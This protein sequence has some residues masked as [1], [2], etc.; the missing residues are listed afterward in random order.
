MQWVGKTVRWT[1]RN[2]NLLIKPQVFVNVCT[3]RNMSTEEAAKRPI[4]LLGTMAFGGRAN[5]EQS[6]EMVQAFLG[7]GHSRVDTAFMYVDGKSEEVIGGMKLPK[8]VS[9]ATKANPW[10]GKTLKPESVRAQLETSLQRL[11]ADCVDLFYLHAPDHNNPIQDTLRACNDLHKEGKFK[12]L[13]LSNYASWEVAEIVSIC[14]H[15]N[16]IVPTVY[17]GMYN[18]TTRQVETELFPCL[19]YFGMSFYAYNPLAGGLLTGKYHY[20]DKDA[21]QP[22]GRFFGN[23]WAAAYRDRYWKQS[24]FDAITQVLKTLEEVYGA[25]K[26]SLTSAAMRWMYHHSK[27]KGDLGDGVII[28]MSNM[29]Q[30]KQNLDAAEEGPLDERVVSAFN[31]AWNRVAHECPNYFR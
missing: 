21:S 28:G 20:E 23:S 13:G 4:T 18:A 19:R 2:N 6:R 3:A 1:L 17:Q 15:N 12:E 29:E 24:Q 9:L 7:R 25:D 10:D 26:P 22:E 31:E 14:K 16:W 30:L 27:L 5:A 11:Q 8:T